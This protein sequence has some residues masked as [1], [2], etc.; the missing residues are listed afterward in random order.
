MEKTGLTPNIC[1]IDNAQG[2]PVKHR[3]L[4]SPLCDNLN[5]KKERR[6]VYYDGFTLL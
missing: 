4:Y 2:P 1:K 3:K 6:Y 5:E